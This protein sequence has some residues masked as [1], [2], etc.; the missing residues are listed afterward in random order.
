[1][2]YIIGECDVVVPPTLAEGMISKV[3]ETVENKVKVVRVQDAGHVMHV[4][5]PDEVVTVVEGVVADLQKAS[6]T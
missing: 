4:S 2:V 6:A 3:A 5:K 1:V